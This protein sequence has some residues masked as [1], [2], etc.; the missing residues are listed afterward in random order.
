MT[1][2]GI[3]VAPLDFVVIQCTVNWREINGIPLFSSF[4]SDMKRDIVF[5]PN[6]GIPWQYR[7]HSLGFVVPSICRQLLIFVQCTVKLAKY[8]G[9]PL[10]G[11]L[12]LRKFGALAIYSTLHSSLVNMPIGMSI[13]WDN[14]YRYLLKPSIG[15]RI[16]RSIPI[17]WTNTPREIGAIGYC[18]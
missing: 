1:V 12:N 18:S 5:L 13:G 17:A 8:Y 3:S 14:A 6:R 11:I 16:F 15:M 2:N 4:K 9:I 10:F 7:Y